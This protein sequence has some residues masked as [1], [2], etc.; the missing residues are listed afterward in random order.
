MKDPGYWIENGIFSASECDEI[1]DCLSQVSGGR[2]RGG[3]RNLMAIPEIERLANDPRLLRIGEKNTG[4][5]LTPFKG[6]LFEKTGKANWLVSFHQDTSL[7]LES[8]VIQEG[9]GPTSNKAGLIYA[10]APT[11]ALKKILAIRIHLDASTIENG[12]LRVIPNSHHERIQI[13]HDFLRQVET[14]GEVQ[15]LVD[16]GGIIAMSPLLIHA[17]S[18]AVN[19]EPRRVLHI[20]YTSSLDLAPGIRLA[21]A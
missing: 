3:V 20:E 12:P 13:D 18:K 10:H 4:N 1:I 8:E 6:T 2:R 7:P 9:W 19:N 21:I 16:K 11:W 15:L 14:G 17:S 5:V